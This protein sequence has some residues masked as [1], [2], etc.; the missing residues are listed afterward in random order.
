MTNK[1]RYIKFCQSERE[2]PIF[3]QFWWLDAVCGI[4]N[5]DVALVEKGGHIMA[6]MPYYI[7]KRAVFKII[8]M[9]TPTQTMGPYLKH[10]KGQK[11]YKKLSFEKEMINKLLEQLPK[12]DS[13][14][15]NF[16]YS[17]TNWQP[18]YWN[19]FNQ[20]TVYTYVI[21]NTSI[22]NLEKEFE[23]D[24]RRRRRRAIN[25][26]LKVI[27]SDNIE[28]FYKLNVETFRR[29]NTNTPY[30][31]E[32]VRRLYKACIEN[33][34]CKL[35]FALDADDDVISGGFF[36]YDTNSV[37]YLMGGINS[38]K[39]NLGGMDIVIYEAIKFALSTNRKFDF[40]GSMKESIEKYFRTFGAEQKS[41][42][43]ISKTNSIL[44]KIRELIQNQ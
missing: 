39:K 14:I 40:A 5:W 7:K 19:G 32:L 12:Y 11:Y 8:T 17:I 33:D 2:I 42:M 37:Y 38:N 22:E 41:M 43:Q 27:E 35:L 26:G 3:S 10:P 36:V 30:S 16:H 24:T 23:T 9:P 1:D 29:Q 25:L 20:K 4:N 21:E 6:T 31:F 44:L 13:F 15:Q 18:F 34:S 28:R